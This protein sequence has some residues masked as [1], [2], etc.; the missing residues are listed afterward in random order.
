MAQGTQ[1]KVMTRP[2]ERAVLDHVRTTRNPHR[3]RVLFL[4]SLKAGLRAKEIAALK[5][6]TWP[7]ASAVEEENARKA[8]ENTDESVGQQ[9]PF[10]GVT[11]S[12]IAVEN[13]HGHGHTAPAFTGLEVRGFQRTAEASWQA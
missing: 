1:A 9:R 3:D 8:G 10:T 6:G 12:R 13:R 11:P 2:Q 5:H 7:A 4:F